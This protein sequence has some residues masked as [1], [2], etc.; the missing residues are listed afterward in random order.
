MMQGRM[1]TNIS[2]WIVAFSCLGWQEIPGADK[3]GQFPT[4]KEV[5][6]YLDYFADKFDLRQHIKTE[7]EVIG[8]KREE[9]NVQEGGKRWSVDV[10]SRDGIV[11]KHHFDDLIIATGFFAIPKIPEGFQSN[12][13]QS[14]KVV[15]S[16]QF[17]GL[18]ELLTPSPAGKKILV[19]GGS[20]S[21]TEVA[22]AVAMEISAETNSP[23]TSDIQDVGKYTVHHV[24]RR[25]FW[26]LPYF[27]P[28]KPVL[29]DGGV[30][31]CYLFALDFALYYLQS[32]VSW[33]R[34]CTLCLRSSLT[35]YLQVSNPASSF[36][37]LD[38]VMYD[39]NRRPLGPLQ[40]YSGQIT[41]EAAI[42]AN[43]RFQSIVGSDQSEFC[44]PVS[45]NEV[46]HNSPLTLQGPVRSEA[47]WIAISDHYTEFV[48]SGLIVPRLGQV[49]S[50]NGST[51]VVETAI[52]K[53]EID[54]IAAVILATGFEADHSI[55]VLPT[56]VLDTLSFDQSSS[57]FPILLDLHMTSCGKYPD[58]GF[59]G[60]Y[61]GPYWG[62]ME[63]QA[64]LL[65]DIFLGKKHI[66]DGAKEMGKLREVAK[67]HP[68]QLAQFPMGDYTYLMESLR[69]LL[70]SP[71]QD[72]TGKSTTGSRGEGIARL[73]I[74]SD[75]PSPI[76]P[77]RYPSASTQTDF[78]TLTALA[79]TLHDASTNGK[80]MARAI[81]R[82]LHGK[83]SL[84]RSLKSRIA[85]YPSG[86]FIGSAT[87]KPRKPTDVGYE[88]EYLFQED[89]EFVTELGMKF[90][91]RRGY[92][93]SHEY[94]GCPL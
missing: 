35:Q 54:D 88:A 7:H 3:I 17:R 23:V 19:V 83:W 61:R 20:M 21:G 79:S 8:T 39:L 10:K 58:L 70:A 92:V 74:N 67:T 69:S 16:T 34:F 82:A 90:N 87:F 24:V 5:S 29:E 66:D 47:P 93:T 22:S 46:S 1:R 15:H 56:E 45:G 59:V 30:K 65:A 80:F 44:P 26:V 18:K 53:T 48:R 28:G 50:E 62:V 6:V 81:F 68:T 85:T 55:S 42:Q 75:L 76:V 43:L 9:G 84:H 89:G 32:V 33:I 38:L 2:R 64:R 94:F 11:E 41:P 49:N 27:L 14:H 25:P 37:P 86:T 63:L 13:T 73:S 60:Y 57:A 51:V 72:I 12:S 91:A 52:D 78:N 31:V 36:L 71:L 77:S 4:A 40:N